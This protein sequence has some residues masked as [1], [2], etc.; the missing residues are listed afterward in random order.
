M[1]LSTVDDDDQPCLRATTV[2]A[3]ASFL[4]RLF[5]GTLDSPYITGMETISSKYGSIENPFTGV[6]YPVHSRDLLRSERFFLNSEA[7]SRTTGFPAGS[8][9]R[10]Y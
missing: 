5:L 4:E 9:S 7:N 6:E 3:Y 2:R 1:T 8:I 10:P